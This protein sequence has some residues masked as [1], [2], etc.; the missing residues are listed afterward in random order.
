MSQELTLGRVESPMLVSLLWLLV[1]SVILFVLSISLI[2][3]RL[4]KRETIKGKEFGL[5]TARR[6]G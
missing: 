2:V 3:K 6:L 5:A 1:A 4:I